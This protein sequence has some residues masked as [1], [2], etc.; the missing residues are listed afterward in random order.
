[1]PYYVS[2]IIR[3]KRTKILLLEVNIKFHSTTLLFIFSSSNAN[4][5]SV[6]Q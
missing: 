2:F 1:M 6:F 4:R 5:V 3:L